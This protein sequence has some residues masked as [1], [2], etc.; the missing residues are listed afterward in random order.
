MAEA[1]ASRTH[2]RQET[3]R[4]PVLKTGTITGPHALPCFIFNMLP[5]RKDGRPAKTGHYSLREALSILSALS[6]HVEGQLVTA[7]S[8]FW[9]L[10][11]SEIKGLKWEDFSYGASD[12]CE[13]CKE[14]DWDI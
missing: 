9:G 6:E 12:G 13:V 7:L 2:R 1:S 8:F 3:C 11:P 14:G 5:D 4:P 10:R